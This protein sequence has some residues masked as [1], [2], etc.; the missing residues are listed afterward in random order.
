MAKEIIIK[1][2][3]CQAS[4]KKDSHW[5][6]S[7]G[8]IDLNLKNVGAVQAQVKYDDCCPDCARAL[9]AAIEKTLVLLKSPK[10]KKNEKT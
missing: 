2:D 4:Q 10:G 6:Q 7:F 1:C 9:V 5:D 8:S 3:I